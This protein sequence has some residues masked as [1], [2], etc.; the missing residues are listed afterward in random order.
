MNFIPYSQP[1]QPNYMMYG[2]IALVL[3]FLVVFIYLWQSG[4]LTSNPTTT[5]PPSTTT[6]SST[7][8][9]SHT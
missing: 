6:P 3:L 1:T 5:T 9:S 2:G 4:K 7:T 8:K